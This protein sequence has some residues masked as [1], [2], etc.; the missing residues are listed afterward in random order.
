MTS[1]SPMNFP[2]WHPA[3]GLCWSFSSFWVVVQVIGSLLWFLPLFP[4]GIHYQSHLVQW[5]HRSHIPTVQQVLWPAGKHFTT[6]W[7]FGLKDVVS[8]EARFLPYAKHTFCHLPENAL[9]WGNLNAI[10]NIL[11]KPRITNPKS[12]TLCSS[13]SLCI[14]G[15]TWGLLHVPSVTVLLSLP[16]LLHMGLC[17]CVW[18]PANLC[19]RWGFCW[20][21]CFLWGDFVE[22]R[23][24]VHP[25]RANKC[26][27]PSKTGLLLTSANSLCLCPAGW[28]FGEQALGKCRALL[29][30]KAAALAITS[31]CWGKPG[32]RW[33]QEGE[34]RLERQLGEAGL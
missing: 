16:G 4:T 30:Q 27:Y 21:F 1:G 18:I 3:V 2:G 22:V 26:C 12:W 31:W 6:S 32:R 14:G 19:K 29:A 9:V 28:C 8:W 20:V 17:R 23:P 11:E 34:R 5:V 15:D 25:C 10:L 7:G 13:A 33:S 24:K